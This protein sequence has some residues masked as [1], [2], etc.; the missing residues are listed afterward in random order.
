MLDVE[1]SDIR[2][3]LEEAEVSSHPGGGGALGAHQHKSCP[4][5]LYPTGDSGTRGEQN[6]AISD[7]AAAD[8][9]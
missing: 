1:K 4:P 8:Q 9:D 5:L 6:P 7:G 2:A 3:A